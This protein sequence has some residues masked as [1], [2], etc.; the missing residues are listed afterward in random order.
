MPSIQGT[1]PEVFNKEQSKDSA[2]DLNSSLGSGSGS[3]LFQSPCSVGTSEES[4]EGRSRSPCTCVATAP[5]SCSPHCVCVQP[6]SRSCSP[7]E[8]PVTLCIKL[9][10]CERI[11]RK[12]DCRRDRIKDVIYLAHCFVTG[13]KEIPLKVDDVCLTDNSV[14]I[15][16]YSDHSLT[17][18][19]AGLIHNTLLHFF[20]N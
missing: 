4:L 6:V 14:P 18:Y 7:P 17:L 5:K 12:F 10:N 3:L 1:N 13:E 15:N 20:Y 19:E 16:T 2:V 8:H 9:P 11:E